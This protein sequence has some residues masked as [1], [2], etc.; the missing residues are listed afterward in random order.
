MLLVLRSSLY[1]PGSAMFLSQMRFAHRFSVMSG[2]TIDRSPGRGPDMRLRHG[3]NDRRRTRSAHTPHRHVVEILII[4]MDG[5]GA[6]TPRRGQAHFC[7]RR[8]VVWHDDARAVH[9]A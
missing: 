2:L 1:D 7:M 4:A 6:H 5:T 9:D 3:Q 8:L